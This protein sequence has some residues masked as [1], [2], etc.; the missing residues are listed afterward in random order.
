MVSAS[1]SDAP[2]PFRPSV[3]LSEIGVKS[4]WGYAYFLGR[5]TASVLQESASRSQE[6]SLVRIPARQKDVLDVLP[7]KPGISRQ[8]NIRVLDPRGKATRYACERDD[9]CAERPRYHG[10]DLRLSESGRGEGTRRE[11]VEWERGE[12]GLIYGMEPASSRPQAAGGH[13]RQ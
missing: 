3:Q 12:R 8:G 9:R 6:H 7:M 2:Q 1:T 4:S 13:G 5:G 11:A 10:D